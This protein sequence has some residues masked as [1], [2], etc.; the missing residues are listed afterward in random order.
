MNDTVWLLEEHDIWFSA[1]SRTPYGIFSTRE[2]AIEAI[3][4]NYSEKALGVKNID[5]YENGTNQWKS[6]KLNCGISI[7]EVQLNTFE[8]M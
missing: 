3:Y 2:K 4:E 5:L 6:D 8:E 1:S 7:R